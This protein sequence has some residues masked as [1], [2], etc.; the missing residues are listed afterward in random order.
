MGPQATLQEKRS[1][2]AEG[3]NHKL[4]QESQS[5]LIVWRDSSVLNLLNN[6]PTRE[7]PGTEPR[8][9]L[10]EVDVPVDSGSGIPGN[11][12]CQVSDLFA[13]TGE[14]MLEKLDI[15]GVDL[16]SQRNKILCQYIFH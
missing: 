13:C 10:D 12:S 11:N 6:P 3:V 2:V 14:Q 4:D 5:P 7:I 16:L 15:S 1:S 9:L 8:H